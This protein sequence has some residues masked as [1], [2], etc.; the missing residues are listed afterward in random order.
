[1]AKLKYGLLDY[2]LLLIIVID[3]NDENVI[4]WKLNL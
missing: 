3:G 1:M 2:Y 4:F